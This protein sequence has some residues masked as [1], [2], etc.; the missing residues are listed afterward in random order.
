ME[1][2]HDGQQMDD[3]YDDGYPPVDGDL[4][5]RIDAHYDDG[6]GLAC[7]AGATQEAFLELEATNKGLAGQVPELPNKLQAKEAALLETY[8]GFRREIA[9]FLAKT[10]DQG[11]AARIQERDE[12][13]ALLERQLSKYD[14]KLEAAQ[15][16]FLDRKVST[17]RQLSDIKA[18]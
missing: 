1:G 5:G 12:L 11:C 7:P 4:G 9:K 8:Q 10:F 2:G 15:Q 18:L 16:A 14:A 3:N 13:K 6:R 17:E